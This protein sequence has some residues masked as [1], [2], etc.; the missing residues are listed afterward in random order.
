[1][2]KL[3][4][5]HPETGKAIEMDACLQSLLSLSDS[6]LYNGGNIILE[7]LDN[8][9]FEVDVTDYIASSWFKNAD[10]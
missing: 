10:L 7:Y 6:P 1:M 9:S 3:R 5:C 2:Q 8:E 4:L